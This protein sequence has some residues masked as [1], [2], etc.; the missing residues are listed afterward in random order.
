MKKIFITGSN[1][2]VG[3]SLIKELDQ[4]HILYLAGDRKY[5]GDIE[6]QTNWKELLDDCD[7]VVHLAARVHVMEEKEIDPLVAFRK[8]NVEATINLAQAAKQVGVKRFI[9]ISSIKVNG[10]ETGEAPFSADDKP[11]PQDPYGVSK[12]EA[13]IELMQLHEAGI[14]EVVII[15]PPL[16]YG[17]GVKANFEKLFWL[18][19]KD[20]PIPFGRVLNKRSLV[21]VFNLASLIIHCMDHPKAS[22]EVFLVSDDKNYSL[23]DLIILMGK[24]LG[25]HPHILPVPVGLMKCG[26]SFI[27]KTSYADR[28]FGNLHVDIEKTKMLLDWKPPFTFEETFKR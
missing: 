20:L 2:F 15:R 16:I 23:R 10:E 11:H 17:P 7:V 27:G 9:Y 25:K 1:G 8:I 21:S 19:K 5:Y 18:V 28:L 24:T 12:M 13:E 3:K 6:K 14:F 26:L 4:K 22:G